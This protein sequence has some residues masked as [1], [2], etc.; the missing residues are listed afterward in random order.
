MPSRIAHNLVF[1]FELLYAAGASA[2]TIMKAIGVSKA[3]AYRL[4][5]N[6]DFWGTP[7]PPEEE[8][9]LGRTRSL[10]EGHVQVGWR[11]SAQ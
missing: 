8:Y 6:M 9:I 11:C 10:T 5:S 1:Q 7:Y 4:I 2:A 3:T